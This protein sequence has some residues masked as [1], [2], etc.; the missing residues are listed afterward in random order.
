MNRWEGHELKSWIA[1]AKK[2]LHHNVLAVTCQQARAIARAPC[3]LLPRPDNT[4]GQ[5]L[6][7]HPHVHCIAPGGGLAHD[8]RWVPPPGFFLPVRVLSRLRRRLFLERLPGYVGAG[9]LNFFG[10]LAALADPAA[11]ARHEPAAPPATDGDR[12]KR[13]EEAVA[14]SSKSQLGNAP[15]RANRFD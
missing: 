1:A 7:H 14:T 9:Q 12:A 2:R 4:W 5:T 8:G 15:N 13:D 11:F 6:T 10:D 3:S